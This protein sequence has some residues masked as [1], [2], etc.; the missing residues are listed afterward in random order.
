MLIAVSVHSALGARAL[1]YYLIPYSAMSIGAFAVV[2]SRERELNKSEITLDDLAGMGWERPLLGV[3]M[4]TFML[5]FAG[6]PLT[7]GF[8]GKLYVFAAAYKAGWWWLIVASA[9]VATVS[10]FLAARQQPPI[11]QSRATIMVGRAIENPHPTGNDFY[12]TQ[13]LAGTYADIAKHHQ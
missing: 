4:W 6:F 8:V 3:A 5:G 11:Y 2:A 10:S 9:F 1:L 12:L 7:G 13:Q